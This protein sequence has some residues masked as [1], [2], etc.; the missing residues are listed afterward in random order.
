MTLI[1]RIPQ[2]L[3]PEMGVWVHGGP[4]L[5]FAEMNVG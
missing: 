3:V 2:K 4:N 5:A 1:F